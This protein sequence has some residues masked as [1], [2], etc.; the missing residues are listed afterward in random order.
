[1]KREKL[2]EQEIL[3][4]LQKLPGWSLKDGKLHRI[5]QCR[6]FVHAWGFMSGC[7]L[8]AEKLDHHP[9]WFNVWNKVEVSLS[10]HSAGGVTDF[11]FALAE[12]MQAIFGG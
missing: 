10:T 7:A 12:K 5:F 8:A 4:R 2:S 9:E 11:D 3:A 1:M 6:D